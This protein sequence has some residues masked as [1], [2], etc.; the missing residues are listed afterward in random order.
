MLALHADQYVEVRSRSEEKIAS[1]EIYPRLYVISQETLNARK[2]DFK[3][4]KRY[5]E[6]EKKLANALKK[7]LKL[8]EN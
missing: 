3:V 7:S 5:H 2:N 4:C 1:G 6:E 8:N